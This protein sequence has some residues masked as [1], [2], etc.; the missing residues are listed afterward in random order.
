MSTHADKT[1]ENISS[2]V[3]NSMQLQQGN[4]QGT[5]QAMHS[6]QLKDMIENSNGVRQLRT[7]AE[8]ANSSPKVKQLEAYKNMVDDYSSSVLQRK[9]QVAINQTNITASGVSGIN[10]PKTVVQRVVVPLPGAAQLTLDMAPVQ[11]AVIAA[12]LVGLNEEAGYRICNASYMQFNVGYTLINDSGQQRNISIGLIQNAIQDDINGSYVND[13]GDTIVIGFGDPVPFLDGGT[14]GAPWYD[15]N[16]ART[17][18]GFES[19][20]IVEGE[21]TLQDRPTIAIPH[22]INSPTNEEYT[23]TALTGTRGL[24]IWLGIQEN[25]VLIATVPVCTWTINVVNGS[26]NVSPGGGVP[27]LQ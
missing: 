6:N 13:G 7:Y 23:S 25:N 20:E 10:D 15:A 19:G 4:S 27:T 11:S 2:A 16:S 1:Q 17:H 12:A 14:G 18:N 9:E 8:M 24:R 3:A 22:K 21:L 5:L 26:V